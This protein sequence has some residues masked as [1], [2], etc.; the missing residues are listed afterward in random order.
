MTDLRK[1]S[2]RQCDCRAHDVC[3][4][5]TRASGLLRGSGQNI[6]IFI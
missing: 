3:R 2:L 4:E 5:T 1:I 6:D